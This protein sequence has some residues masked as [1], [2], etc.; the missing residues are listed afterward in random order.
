MGGPRHEARV[1]PVI[2]P[3]TENKGQN[4]LV[5]LRTSVVIADSDKSSAVSMVT[6]LTI[7]YVTELNLKRA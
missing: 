4:K 7:R 6:R 3:E 2:G 1:R 5:R